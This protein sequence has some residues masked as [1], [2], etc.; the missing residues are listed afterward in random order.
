MKKITLI[1][2]PHASGKTQKAKQLAK[3]ISHDEVYEFVHPF[4]KI[5]AETFSKIPSETKLVIINSIPDIHELKEIIKICTDYNRTENPLQLF[6]KSSFFNRVEINNGLS[7][8]ELDSI[9]IIECVPESENV[10]VS[11]NSDYYSRKISPL[12]SPINLIHKARDIFNSMGLGTLKPAE[13]I[14]LFSDPENFVKEK[15]I[16]GKKFDF[17][18]VPINKQKL[19]TLIELPK[20]FDDLL[21]WIIGLNNLLEGFER[22]S[23]FTEGIAGLIGYYN[24]DEVCNISIKEKVIKN[25]TRESEIW[26][27]NEKAK[28]YFFFGEEFLTLLSKYRI[29]VGVDQELVAKVIIVENGKYKINDGFIWGIETNRAGLSK[30]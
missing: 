7:H 3:G 13:I 24:I 22:N 4:G 9:E 23:I 15:M 27:S 8:E 18:G 5:T 20:N 6:L 10:L 28:K 19:K 26:V 30:N 12:D 2:G 29:P 14:N 16:A 1:I 11:F 25:I 17:A 21:K